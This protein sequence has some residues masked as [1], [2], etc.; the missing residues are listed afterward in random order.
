MRD[1]LPEFLGSLG[2]GVLLAVAGVG[3]N[4]FRARRT[5]ARGEGAAGPVV[6]DGDQA[7]GGR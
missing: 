2:A 6:P 4:R 3:V 1:A 7:P 5:A